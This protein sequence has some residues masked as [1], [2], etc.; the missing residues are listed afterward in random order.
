MRRLLAVT[1][2]RLES[3]SPHL[4]STVSI[5]AMRS[6]T[7]TSGRRIRPAGHTVQEHQL[8]EIQV[9]RNNHPVVSGGHLEKCPVAW[10]D[11]EAVGEDD[12]VALVDQPFR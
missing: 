11:T 6:A 8:A 3:E 5:N 12:I 1:M 9:N 4:S 2:A 10:V 7:G